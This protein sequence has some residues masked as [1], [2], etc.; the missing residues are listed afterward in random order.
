MSELQQ[1]GGLYQGII[2]RNQETAG[3]FDLFVRLNS[4]FKFSFYVGSD[5]RPSNATDLGRSQSS[6]AR[7]ERRQE[8]FREHM[9]ALRPD[10]GHPKTTVIKEAR[11]RQHGHGLQ[12][13][14]RSITGCSRS[15]K[16]EAKGIRTGA[17]RLCP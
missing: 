5:Q 8:T 11:R 16:T 9:S 1:H 17:I 15:H 4:L 7:A 6:T 10:E 3:K 12:N 13:T 2:G 14:K